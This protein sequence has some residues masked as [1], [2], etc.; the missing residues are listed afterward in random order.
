MIKNAI[1]QSA[2]QAQKRALAK[3]ICYRLLMVLITIIVAWIIIGDIGNALDIGLITNLLKTGT[4]YLYERIWD[5]I[6]WGIST[7]S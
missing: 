1:S 6:R 3:T 4:Y 5:H 7:P 2:L